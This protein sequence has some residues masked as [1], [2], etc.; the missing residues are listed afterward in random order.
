MEIRESRQQLDRQGIKHS[1]I[2]IRQ[3]TRH[4]LALMHEGNQTEVLES[5]PEISMDES[6][7]FIENYK[8]LLNLCNVVV[9]SGSIP[10]GPGTA[11]YRRLIS[12][13]N[14]KGRKFI[15]D[16]SGD[17]LK[18]GI[19]AHPFLI[20][21]NLHEIELLLKVKIETEEELIN[22]VQRLAQK[23]PENVVISL[24]DKGAIGILNNVLY[25]IRAAKIH[26]VSAVGSGDSMVAGLALGIARG[27]NAK[28]LLALGSCFGALNA[29]E[30][31]TGYIDVNRIREFMDKTEVTSL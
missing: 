12:L 14:K 27:Y 30:S 22:A 16:T 17:A 1:F 6:E 23:G 28:K 26:A 11:F 19:K 8:K 9:A 7:L 13:A 18:E 3:N 31:E 5:G 29:L 2:K 4:C 20:K 25:R 15:L 24:G 10:A 21:P